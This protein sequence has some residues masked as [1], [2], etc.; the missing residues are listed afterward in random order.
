M[1]NQTPMRSAAGINV[2][3]KNEDDQERANAIERIG[4]EKCAHHRGN[5]SAF[6]FCAFTVRD[7]PMPA[8]LDS[9]GTYRE[10]STGAWFQVRHDLD[11]TVKTLP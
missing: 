6:S 1:K 8:S 5:R 9:S 11:V 10:E 4:P 3:R 2:A 7:L